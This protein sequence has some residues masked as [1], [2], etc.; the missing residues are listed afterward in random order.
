MVGLTGAP[1]NPGSPGREGMKGSK[2]DS[3]I[4]GQKGTKG[5]SGAPGSAGP[6][7][8]KGTLG[9]A[10][11]RGAPGGVGPKGHPG[12]KGSSGQKGEKG[13]KGEKGSFAT[14]VRIIGSSSR[15]RAEVYYNEVWG[16]ICDDGW[17]NYD[18]TVFCHMLG[19][20]RGKALGNYGGGTGKIWLD[21]VACQGSE[22]SLWNCNK[23]SW[24]T[25]NCGHSED[26]GVEC[27]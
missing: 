1:G 21:D 27:S 6:K 16:T 19:F 4:Q 14:S 10:G 13:E 3:G 23:S 9:P 25:H 2:G 11:L 24:G 22:S 15:G 8:E 20:S 7:G 26:A 12:E 5:E 18:A 17:D